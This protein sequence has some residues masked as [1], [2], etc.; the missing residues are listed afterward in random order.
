MESDEQV[1]DEKRQK[2]I[3]GINK[4]LIESAIILNKLMFNAKEP[5]T[6]MLVK[7]QMI[8]NWAKVCFDKIA[9]ESTKEEIETAF[10]LA[11]GMKIADHRNMVIGFPEE[12]K[13]NDV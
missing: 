13:K 6:L 10:M 1:N 7:C 4:E 9:E 3:G 5:R 8:G 12:A 11:A 2:L